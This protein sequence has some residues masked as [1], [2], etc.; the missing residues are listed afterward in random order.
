[1]SSSIHLSVLWRNTLLC[2][3]ILISPYRAIT[4]PSGLMN[5]VSNSLLDT[6]NQQLKQD[7]LNDEVNTETILLF[8]LKCV[9]VEFYRVIVHRC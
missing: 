7:Y 5:P 9:R 1:M 6:Y 4:I 8:Y 3:L 2:I